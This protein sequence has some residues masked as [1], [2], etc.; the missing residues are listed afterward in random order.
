MTRIPFAAPNRSD[1]SADGRLWATPAP[2][3]RR[4]SDYLYQALA[5]DIK[6]YGQGRDRPILESLKEAYGQDDQIRTVMARMITK[7]AAIP[8]DTTTS[9]WADTLVQTVIGD[10]TQD[11]IPI[12]VYAKLAALG[13]SYFL[14][15]NG[16]VSIPARNTA[17]TVSGA[18][19]AQGAPIPVRQGQFLPILL[20]LKKMAVI[21]TMTREI[22]I[23]SVPTIESILRDA[24]REDTSV[25]IDSILLDNG[26]ATAIRP[27]GL[28]N[29]TKITASG[30]ASIVG[31][32][33]DLK[34]LVTVLITGAR[35]NLRVPVWLMNPVDA[36]AASIT[37][38]AGSGDMP[39]GEQLSHG[40]LLGI[41][42]ILSS[43][44]AADS[45]LLVDAADFVTISSNEPTFDVSDQ[46]TL[47]LEDTVPLALMTGGSTPTFASPVRNMFQ[48]DSIA[49]KMV[50]PM[51]WAMR[52]TGTVAWT[53]TIAWSP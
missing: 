14:G 11:L 35:G 22:M 36:L 27:V 5:V 52:R 34:A 17:A 44:V 16:I 21:T 30:T 46:V 43:N 7:A 24:M 15:R 51:N 1:Y 10:F 48:Q 39:F 13:S 18:F 23:H 32:I 38:A 40:M 19:V 28:K 33:A 41:P 49:I 47:H 31:L 2:R 50:W 12:C 3:A 6:N 9:G 29:V 26:A 45:L 8:A 4:P 25:A 37:Q 20:G 53:D 42:V